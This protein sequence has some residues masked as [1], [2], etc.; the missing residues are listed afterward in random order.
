MN[1]L[2]DV[3]VA[4][5][6]WVGNALWDGALWIGLALALWLPLRR[7]VPAQLGYLLFVVVLLR[8]AVPV[9]LPVPEWLGALSPTQWL[10]ATLS[11]AAPEAVAAG[12]ASTLSATA[13]ASACVA[14]SPRGSCSAASRCCRR[15]SSTAPPTTPSAGR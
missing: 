6:G 12:P 4:W 14:P 15:P 5:V 2:D 8:V 10:G 13:A 1:A 11:P 9:A 3:A 7:W